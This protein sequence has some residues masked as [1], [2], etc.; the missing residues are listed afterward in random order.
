L[1]AANYG[2]KFNLSASLYRIIDYVVTVDYA[3]QQCQS[4]SGNYDATRDDIG[5]KWLECDDRWATF[6]GYSQ[7]NVSITAQ[8]IGAA[9]I[10]SD[11]RVPFYQSPTGDWFTAG[12]WDATVNQ[13]I[14]AYTGKTVLDTSTSLNA[15]GMA[16]IDTSYNGNNPNSTGYVSVYQ[17]GAVYE[18]INAGTTNLDGIATWNVGDFAVAVN[19]KWSRIALAKVTP[20]PLLINGNDVMTLNATC[21]A[22]VD[23]ICFMST[24][25]VSTTA[26]LVYDARI[27]MI[28]NTTS[29]TYYNEAV[30]TGASNIWTAASGSNGDSVTLTGTITASGG[31]AVSVDA[32]LGYMMFAT[33]AS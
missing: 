2:R 12:Q 29:N 10:G 30:Y 25:L 8:S 7:A 23:I 24:N 31:T 33:G 20:A 27:E 15:N 1:R 14:Q 3:D 4:A 32:Y 21:A 17:E 16:T 26:G 22:S 5:W 13:I 18:V 11:L 9:I 6:N 19:G 28:N